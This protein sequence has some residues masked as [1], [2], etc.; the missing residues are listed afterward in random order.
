MFVYKIINNINNKLYI[1][2]TTKTIEKRWSQHKLCANHKLNT[3]LYRAMN[4]YGIDSF[5]ISIIHQGSSL[6]EI[7]DMEQKLIKELNTQVHLGNGYNVSYGGESNKMPLDIIKLV[8]LKRIGQK[9][10][11]EQKNRISEARKGKTLLNDHARKYPKETVLLAL[12]LLKQ[13]I[14][15]KDIV[16]I[17]GLTQSYISNLKTNKR[18]K[19]LIGV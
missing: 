19:T 8:S 12:K 16:K 13:N 5:S 4:K 14:L 3:P 1:G 9:R 18:G 15:Q 11:Q 7:L 6:K 17:T 2:I 10:T